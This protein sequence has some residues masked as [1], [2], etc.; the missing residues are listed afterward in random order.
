MVIVSVMAQGPYLDCCN[1]DHRGCNVPGCEE[2]SCRGGNEDGPSSV[3]A[4][5]HA[6]IETYTAHPPNIYEHS[7]PPRSIADKSTSQK[8]L[9]L[10]LSHAWDD[11]DS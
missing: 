9:P 11:C 4:S 5:S 3:R 7:L 8:G 10:L 1:A 2:A 6:S